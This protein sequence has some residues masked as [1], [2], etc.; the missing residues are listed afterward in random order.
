[1]KSKEKEKLKKEAEKVFKESHVAV[2]LEEM[3]DSIKLLAEGQMDLSRRMDR[4]EDK[5]TK[6]EWDTGNNFRLVFDHFSNIEDELTDIKKELRIL[7]KEKAENK[8][9]LELEKRVEKLEK[10]LVKAKAGS[11]V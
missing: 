4:I 6:F 1:M 10:A 2:I 9:V 3:R 11:M 7:K 5:M 8:K